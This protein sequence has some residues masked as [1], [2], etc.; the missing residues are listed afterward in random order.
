MMGKEESE[1]S[2]PVIPPFSSSRVIIMAEDEGTKQ[3][4]EQWREEVTL[5]KPT[6]RQPTFVKWASH[7][8]LLLAGPWPAEEE[9]RNR[10]NIV[11]RDLFSRNC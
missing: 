10:E 6:S 8:L 11:P 1:L 3:S 2:E 4:A 7:L 5:R 9:E